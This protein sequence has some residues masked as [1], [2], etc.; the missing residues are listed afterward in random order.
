MGIESHLYYYELCKDQFEDIRLEMYLKKSF[1]HEERYFW[2][3]RVGLDD[4]VIEKDGSLPEDYSKFPLSLNTMFDIIFVDGSDR[5]K[6]INTALKII[7]NN[8]I[9][10]VHDAERA[11]IWRGV[12]RSKI[13]VI[14]NEFNTVIIRKKT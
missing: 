3:G 6:C 8:G 14:T 5:E 7:K 2:K 10:I 12:D 13:D 9:I 11:S 1:E 4:G